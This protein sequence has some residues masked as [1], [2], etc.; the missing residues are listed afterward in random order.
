MAGALLAA[1]AAAAAGACSGTTKLQAFPEKYA[2]VGLELAV[3]GGAAEVVSVIAGGPA[4]EAG[5]RQGDRI[6]KIDGEPVA[7]LTLADVV[8]K[9][10]GPAGSQVMLSLRQEAGKSD[11]VVVINRRSLAKGQG[12]YKAE[13]GE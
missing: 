9:L 1:F 3:R 10:R 2:G 8:A 11:T 4:E 12:G 7:G 5:L 6:V 13:K